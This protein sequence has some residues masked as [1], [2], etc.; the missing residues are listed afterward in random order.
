[1]AKAHALVTS[2][3]WTLYALVSPFGFMRL[4][5]A[6]VSL[7]DLSLLS[8]KL[9]IPGIHGSRRGIL[10]SMKHDVG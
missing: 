10:V 2:L 8:F 7:E 9:V 5:S 3:R 4:A 6:S 1:M